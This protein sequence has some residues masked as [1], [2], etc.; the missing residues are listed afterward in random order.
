MQVVSSNCIRPTLQTVPHELILDIIGSVDPK[1]LISLRLTCRDVSACTLVRFSKV[2]F[3][4]RRHILTKHSLQALI[5]ITAHPVYGK[6][7][8][9]ISLGSSRLCQSTYSKMEHW[10][11]FHNDPGIQSRLERLNNAAHAALFEQAWLENTTEG[12]RMLAAAL[13]NIHKYGNAA[14]LG[15][16]V[17]VVTAESAAKDPHYFR[18]PQYRNTLYFSGWGS[19]RSYG[20]DLGASEIE[21]YITFTEKATDTIHL[22]LYAIGFSSCTIQDLSLSIYKG[23]RDLTLGR[24]AATSRWLRLEK[25]YPKIQSV[26][27]HRSPHVEPLD[28]LS[29]QHGMDSGTMA[30]LRRFLRLTTPKKL[31]TCTPLPDLWLALVQKGPSELHIVD[32]AGGFPDLLHILSAARPTLKSLTLEGG[33]LQDDNSLRRLLLWMYNHLKLDYLCII[34]F[35]GSIP[36]YWQTV[37]PLPFGGGWKMPQRQICVPRDSASVTYEGAVQVREGIK[38][39]LA[40]VTRKRR[41]RKT[42]GGQLMGRLSA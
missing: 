9:S 14:T 27:I 8:R 31:K 4:E 38:T 37:S 16:W 41:P 32:F 21:R 35:R 11:S 20:S 34:G 30:S 40:S 15:M 29:R 24:Y 36:Q 13:N 19:L 12:S 25:I 39:L 26:E 7:V 6:D 17:D 22:L 33:G 23:D 3:S 28:P 2:H 42:K 18:N 5:D 1:D 10:L